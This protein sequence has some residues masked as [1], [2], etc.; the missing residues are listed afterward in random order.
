MRIGITTDCLDHWKGLAGVGRYTRMLVAALMRMDSQNEYVLIHYTRTNDPL[1]QG[2]SQLLIPADG[3]WRQV[4][5][6]YVQGPKT[7]GR[8]GCDVVHYAD[9]VGVFASRTDYRK[10]ATVHDLTSL[11][12]PEAHSGLPFVRRLYWLMS[13]LFALKNY[14]RLIAVSENTKRDLVKHMKVPPDKISVVHEGVSPL[15]KPGQHAS[16][17]ISQKYNLPPNFILSVSTLEPR[18]NLPTLIKAYGKSRRKRN[19]KQKLVICGRPGWKCAG[20]FRTVAELGLESEVIF[21]GYAP[22]TDLVAIYNMADLFVYPS[23]YEGFGLPPL[24]AMACGVPVITS[25]ASSLPEVVGDAGITLDPYDVDGLAEAMD[26]VLTSATR[27]EDMIQRG[28]ARAGLFTWE[29][30]ATETV[31]VYEDVV[32]LQ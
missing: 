20:V 17:A 18:K 2:T 9:G 23:L 16:P 24:E 19:L 31:R 1:Y 30:A 32:G 25:N 15:F 11:L 5:A 7:L 10:V 22:D 4:L 6:R 13:G 21:T 28:L 14:D 8:S 29:R 26:L 27:Q 12:Y 3:A